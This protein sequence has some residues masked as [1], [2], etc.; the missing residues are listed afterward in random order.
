[1]ND[2]GKPVT[3]TIDKPTTAVT[4]CV[5]R[6]TDGNDA[7]REVELTRGSVSVGSAPGQDLRLADPTVS[8]QHARVTLVAGGVEVEDLKSR[9]GTLYL[10]SQVSRVILPIGATVRFGRTRVQVASRSIGPEAKDRDCYGAL[11]GSSAVMQRLYA[12]LGQLERHG[13]P[14]LILGE[15]GVGKELVAREIHAHSSRRKGSYEVCDCTTLPRT[16]AESELFG[17]TRGA[18]TGAVDTRPGVFERADNGTIFIDEIGELPIDLQ[19]KLL[20]VLESHEVRRVGSAELRKIDVRVIA[21]TNRDLIVESRAGRFREDLFY[22]LNTV[23]IEV[24]PLRERREDVPALV[25]K[26]I[27]D[28]ERDPEVISRET[29]ELFTTGYDWPGNVR[30]LRNAVRRVLAL[31]TPPQGLPGATGREESAA[32][33]L[34]TNAQFQDAKRTVVDAFERDYLSAQMRLADNN[35][36]HAARSSGVERMQFK[37]LLKKHGLI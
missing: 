19:P 33:R 20:R 17:H 24:P 22:R 16:L 1:M 12:T 2:F 32:S 4:G 30:E 14:V 37:R 23:T 9:N 6:V 7:G 11:M 15:T 27:D 21:A 35:I 31:G 10:E 36:S 34:D 13:Y 5:L 8:G 26:F 29:L 25:R 28:E 18:F 3:E